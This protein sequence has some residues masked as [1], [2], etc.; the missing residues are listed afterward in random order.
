[1][2]GRRLRAR[3]Q[4]AGSAGGVDALPRS[5][6]D[7]IRRSPCHLRLSAGLLRT[8]L[9]AAATCCQPSTI[10]P[11]PSLATLLPYSFIAIAPAACAAAIPRRIRCDI[12]ASNGARLT[13]VAHYSQQPPRLYS[14]CSAP[15]PPPPLLAPPAPSLSHFDGRQRWAAFMGCHETDLAFCATGREHPAPAAFSAFPGATGLGHLDCCAAPRQNTAVWRFRLQPR[16]LARA[17]S[18]GGVAILLPPGRGWARRAHRERGISGRAGVSWSIRRGRA[19]GLGGTFFSCWACG[20]LAGFS[21]LPPVK[22][23]STLLR[24]AC[25][26]AA[27]G[28]RVGGQRACVFW[29]CYLRY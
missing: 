29:P 5:W 11:L 18:G 13:P 15:S 8:C 2:N 19:K 4:R 25:I 6:R 12:A 23:H 26:L 3:C 14:S 10:P 27:T 16:G 9:S 17:T 28:S 7:A 1:L 21:C 24:S 22:P 20:R